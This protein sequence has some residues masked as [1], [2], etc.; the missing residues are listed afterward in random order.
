M[1]LDAD[2]PATNPSRAKQDARKPTRITVTLPPDS[3]DT[4]V[5]MAKSKRVSTSWVV[6]DAVSKYVET[7]FSTAPKTST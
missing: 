6:R 5:H 3:Y 2:M 1:H 7:E 4:V